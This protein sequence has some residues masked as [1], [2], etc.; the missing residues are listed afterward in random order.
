MSGVSVSRRAPVVGVMGG[1]DATPATLALAEELG[2]ALAREGWT[3][4]SGGRPVG[5]ME[6][7]SRGAAHAGG[8]VVAVLP[9]DDPQQATP[10]ATVVVASG[11][12]FARNSMNVLSSDVVVALPGSTGTL[13]EIAYAVS[14]G[15][16]VLLLGWTEQPLAGLRLPRLETVA[17]TVAA[18]RALLAG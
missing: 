4:L 17:E 6:A 12:G 1:V 9:G 16:P 18:L 8:Q 3:V 7:V 14:Y 5:V 13:S 11:I 15:R 10:Y 2:S